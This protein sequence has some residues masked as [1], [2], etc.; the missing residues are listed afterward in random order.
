MSFEPKFQ[1]LVGKH[2]TKENTMEE[3]HVTGTVKNKVEKKALVAP[4]AIPKAKS[5]AS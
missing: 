4:P 3:H 1:S 2:T 5:K